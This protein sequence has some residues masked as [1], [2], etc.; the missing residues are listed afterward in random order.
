[1]RKI[2]V[3]KN[4]E[5]FIQEYGSSKFKADNSEIELELPEDHPLFTGLPSSFKHENGQLTF[6]PSKLEEYN[7]I[8][9]EIEN[10]PKI[11]EEVQQLKSVSSAMLGG[12]SSDGELVAKSLNHALR[13]FAQTLP[14][15]KALEVAAMYPMWET[16]KNYKMN[17][18]VQYGLNPDNEPQIYRTLQAHKSQADWTPDKAVSLF[19]KIGFTPTGTPTWV[20]PL[21]AT[22]AY[23]KNDEVSHKGVI[24]TSNID[25]NVWEPGVYGWTIKK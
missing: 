3:T 6:V 17:E 20:Q 19:K 25:G 24:Y 18:Y 9:E 14:E 10:Q 16:N 12:E 5:G 22:D 11:E 2:F 21:G 23:K 1:M 15:D 7:Q 13:L 8:V 4:S